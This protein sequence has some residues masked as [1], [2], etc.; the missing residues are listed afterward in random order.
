MGQSKAGLRDHGIIVPSRGG[1]SLG[2]LQQ[3][4][5]FGNDPRA[6]PFQQARGDLHA[7]VVLAI[8]Q[9]ITEHARLEAV[10]HLQITAALVIAKARIIEIEGQGRG[11]RQILRRGRHTGQQQTGQQGKS[12]FHD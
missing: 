7:G 8:G 10:V 11:R 1:I 6:R 4:A 5:L 3:R 9:V 12:R 2:D